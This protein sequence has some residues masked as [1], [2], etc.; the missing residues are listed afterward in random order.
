MFEW[1]QQKNAANQ[2]KHGIS[3]D[4][5]ATVVS[6]DYA[7]LIADPDHSTEE[8]RFLL[9]GKSAHST[10]LVVCHCVRIDDVIRIIS[11]RKANKQERNMYE[12]FRYA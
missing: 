11:V 9:L 6:D 7:R 8:E 1:N 12:D 4:E 3:F 2:K 5:A 10:L